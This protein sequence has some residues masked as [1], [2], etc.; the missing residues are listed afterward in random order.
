M[1]KIEVINDGV[2]SIGKYAFY[3]CSNLTSVSISNTVTNIG[4]AAFSP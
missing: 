3:G 4:T 1:S 2:T